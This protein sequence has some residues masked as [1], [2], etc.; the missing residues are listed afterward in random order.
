MERIIELFTEKYGKKLPKSLVKFTKGILGD[1]TTMFVSCYLAQN[2]KE[3]INGYFD[4]DMFNIYFRVRKNGE[5]SYVL[6]NMAKSYFIKPTSEYYAYSRRE[7]SFRK[8]SGNA[9]KITA[10][11]DKFLDQLMNALN[12]DLESGNIHDNHVALLKEK[13]GR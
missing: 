1:N 11:F 5:D 9:E 13:L 7:L 10:S 12:E 3:E 6:E 8:T 4:N 2:E